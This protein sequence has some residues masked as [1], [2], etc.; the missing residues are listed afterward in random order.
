MTEFWFDCWFFRRH[1]RDQTPIC[2]LCVSEKKEVSRRG[3][4]GSDDNGH[5][6]SNYGSRTTGF[7]YLFS[8]QGA[9]TPAAGMLELSLTGQEVSRRGSVG[10][11]DNGHT[12]VVALRADHWFAGLVRS[13]LF[14]T[15]N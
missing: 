4:V 6:H 12:T 13:E 1:G 14:I 9:E 11:D 10:S 2:R 15:A 5:T 8:R 7:I 3:S